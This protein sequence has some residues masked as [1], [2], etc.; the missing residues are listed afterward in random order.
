MRISIIIASRNA[1]ST[2]GRCLDSIARQWAGNIEVVVADGGSK[3]G[4]PE[5]LQRR[6]AETGGSLVWLSKPDKGIA[7]AWNRAIALATGDWILFLGAD[8]CLAAP[9]VVMRAEL[10]LERALPRHRVVY[11]Q[12]ALVTPEDV[13]VG[14]LDR[15][16]SPRDFYGCR[17]NLPH[18]AVFHHHSLFGEF[19]PFDTSLK[20]AA[21]FDFLLRA[22]AQSEPLCIPGLTI[23]RMQVG[24]LSNSRLNAPRL[25]NEEMRLFLRHVG[26]IPWTHLWWLAKA[27]AKYALYRLGGDGLALRI[28]NR[29]RRLVRG[30]G[31]LRY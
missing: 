24:G 17:Y 23:T 25:V 10:V 15:P 20:I 19:G 29:Y 6:S 31:P 7:E 11:G 27:W 12:V 5:I 16:W 4:T 22:L 3:D 1:A 26:G 14:M 18:Q 9:D 13:E 28:T 8:D 21:G 30:E 2:I